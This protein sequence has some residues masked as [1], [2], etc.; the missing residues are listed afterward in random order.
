MNGKSVE[1][2]IG[3]FA[4]TFLISLVIIGF[5]GWLASQGM[6]SPERAPYVGI[7]ASLGYAALSGVLASVIEAVTPGDFDNLAIPLVIAIVLVCLGL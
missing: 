4:A 1:G 3:V 6:I 5:Y 7:S 2:S